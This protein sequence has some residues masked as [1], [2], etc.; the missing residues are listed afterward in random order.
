MA[1]VAAQGGI[2]PQI[3]KARGAAAGQ[4]TVET[5]WKSAFAVRAPSY[6][7][8]T[9]LQSKCALAFGLALI[10]AAWPRA[11]DNQIS[12]KGIQ[13]GLPGRQHPV[14]HR[15]DRGTG[16]DVFDRLRMIGRLNV[17]RTVSK[18]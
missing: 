18:K 12:Y 2:R 14:W 17:S 7:L 10:K 4:S 6:R 5:F 16:G 11:R 13:N 9:R 1:V 8:M 3:K 15:R